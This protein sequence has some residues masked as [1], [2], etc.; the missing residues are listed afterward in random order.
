MTGIDSLDMLRRANPR[1]AA[2]GLDI[3]NPLAA[4]TGPAGPRQPN[5]AGRRHRRAMRVAVAAT[6][7]A[8]S[9]VRCR[10]SGAADRPGC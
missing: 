8:D 6:G 7:A 2:P 3:V 10:V 1:H 9:S 4:P 5:R